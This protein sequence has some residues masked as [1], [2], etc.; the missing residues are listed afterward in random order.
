MTEYKAIKVKWDYALEVINQT[1]NDM[2]KKG[3]SRLYATAVLLSGAT[4]PVNKRFPESK[5]LL[6]HTYYTLLE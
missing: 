1:M 6:L 5:K 4:N 2:A 3:R